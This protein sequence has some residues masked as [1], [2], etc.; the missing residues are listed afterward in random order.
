MLHYLAAGNDPYKTAVSYNY[1]NA[2][3]SSLATLCA[4][5]FKVKDDVDVWTNVDF[6]QERQFIEAELSI[7]LRIAQILR[8][9][10]V[11]AFSAFG[12]LVRNWLRRRRESK[13]NLTVN[14]T[15]DKNTNININTEERMDSNG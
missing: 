11:F 10:V 13:N 4:K 9:A 2:A 15:E 6:V 1:V 5:S 12:I 8:V 7:T 3:L 14:N